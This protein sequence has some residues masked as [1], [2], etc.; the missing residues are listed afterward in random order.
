MILHSNPNH[1]HI[2]ISSSSG[3]SHS[4]SA[5]LHYKAFRHSVVPSVPSISISKSLKLHYK[6]FHHSVVSSVTIMLVCL[7]VSKLQSNTQGQC[8]PIVPVHCK[9][10]SYSIDA[11]I[12]HSI[13]MN[14]ISH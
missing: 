3:L 12:K 2:I 11:C 14:M 9:I 8:W 1:I 5:K 13:Y 6:D 10:T 7:S 4:E